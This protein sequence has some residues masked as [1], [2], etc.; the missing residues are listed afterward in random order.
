MGTLLYFCDLRG[1]PKSSLRTPWGSMD[2]RLRTYAL[3]PEVFDPIND[4][5]SEWP[6]PL[7][8]SGSYQC[9]LTWE[10]TF[11]LIG[12]ENNKRGVQSFNHS[13][14]TW[15]ELDASSGPMDVWYSGCAVL[16]GVNFINII[17]ANFLYECLFGSFFYLHTYVCT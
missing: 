1:P 4:N 16:P 3:N 17:R 7:K 11:L 8:P 6:L 10:D 9:C 2:P 14:Q 5:W 12:G 13:T 15:T